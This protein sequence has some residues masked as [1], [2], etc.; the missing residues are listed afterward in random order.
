MSIERWWK[1]L[2][3]REAQAAPRT[4]WLTLTTARQRAIRAAET[5]SG[6]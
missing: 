3:L 4:W 6:E 5:A 2:P 1:A